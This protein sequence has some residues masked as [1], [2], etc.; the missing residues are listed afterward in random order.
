MWIGSQLNNPRQLDKDTP[1]LITNT[2]YVSPFQL[3]KPIHHISIAYNFM[4]AWL[5]PCEQIVLK[6]YMKVM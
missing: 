5:N 3:V 6:I 2:D 4:K 1:K